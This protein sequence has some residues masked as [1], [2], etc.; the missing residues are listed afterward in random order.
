[1]TS[2]MA[3]YFAQNW[4]DGSPIRRSADRLP[5]LRSVDLWRP[6]QGLPARVVKRNNITDLHSDR[7]AL[8]EIAGPHFFWDSLRPN[9]HRALRRARQCGR[10]C[11]GARSSRDRPLQIPL[12][13]GSAAAARLHGRDEFDGAVLLLGPP[14]EPL[15]LEED[16]RPSLHVGHAALPAGQI[17][18]VLIEVRSFQ[19]ARETKGAAPVVPSTPSK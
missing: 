18:L 4:F 11:V 8:G 7:P 9:R 16:E 6:W 5:G 12:C 3:S 19:P 10:R 14:H 15:G 2:G 13:R 17:E 1:M